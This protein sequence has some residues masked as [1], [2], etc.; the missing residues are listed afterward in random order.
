M[1]V[2]DAVAPVVRSVAVAVFES[3]LGVMLDANATGTVNTSELPAP[4]PI[5]APVALKLVPPKLPTTLPQLALPL[6]VHDTFAVSV[7]PAGRRSLTVRFC[8]SLTP[9]SVTV[10]V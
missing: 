9:V 2:S 5:T 8:A 6:A 4:A 3:E 1:S 7:K 10:T